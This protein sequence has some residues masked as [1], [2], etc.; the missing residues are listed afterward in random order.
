MPALKQNQF[1]VAGGGPIKK[2]KLF[3]LWHLRRA[4]RPPAGANRRVFPS[5]GGR[6]L[7]RF[8]RT[9]HN[10]DNPVD[11]ITND[12][13]TDS[14]GNPCVANNKIAPGCISPVAQNLLEFVPQTPTQHWL[15]SASHPVSAICSWG[16]V[17]GIRAKN[18]AYSEAFI[19]RRALIDSP[20]P[21]QRRNDSGLH[22]RK[23]RR[24]TRVRRGKRHLY[25]SP[26]VINQATFS[27]LDSSSNQLQGKTI[28]PSTSVSTCRN[29]C[30]RRVDVNVGGEFRPRIRLHHPVLQAQLSVQG[31]DE[32]D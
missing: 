23:H 25:V 19:T 4:S 28:D 20:L 2:D 31:F 18:T 13:L 15:R 8:H 32:L 11:P 24:Q 30:R 29:T 6:A 7:R 26:T 9:G 16:A 3:R 1:G 12:P 22:V 5:H 14:G 27:F 21:V 17:T 10:A